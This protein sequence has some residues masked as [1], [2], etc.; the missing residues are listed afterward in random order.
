VDRHIKMFQTIIDENVIKER[1]HREN[2][3]KKTVNQQNANA[4]DIIDEG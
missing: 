4:K 2:C 3:D 1:R